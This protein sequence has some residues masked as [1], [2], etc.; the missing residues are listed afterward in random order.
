MQHAKI[1]TEI[2]EERTRQIDHED[3]DRDGDD[4]YN[5]DGELAMG[6]A[7]YA[8]SAASHI[9]PA[10]EARKVRRAIQANVT[11]PWPSGFKP[12]NARRDLIRAAALLVAEVERLDRAEVS[13]VA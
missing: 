8:I 10:G 13:N 2:A 1:L 4:A 5:T 3:R 9:V 7:A 6:A 11:W 12:K